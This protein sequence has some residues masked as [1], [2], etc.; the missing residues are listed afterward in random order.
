MSYPSTLD[1]ASSGSDDDERGGPFAGVADKVFTQFRISSLATCWK[2]VLQVETPGSTAMKTGHRYPESAFS[3][4]EFRT[5]N[6][7][8]PG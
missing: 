3:R 4:S 5:A 1:E 2:V 8:V 6:P 7:R